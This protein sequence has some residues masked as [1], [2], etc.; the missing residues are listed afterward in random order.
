METITKEFQGEKLVVSN[1]D[2]LLVLSLDKVISGMINR[3]VSRSYLIEE[4]TKL[5]F[6]VSFNG[7]AANNVQI[8]QSSDNLTGERKDLVGN[9]SLNGEP[10]KSGRGRK[11]SEKGLKISEYI[12]HQR[13]VGWDDKKILDGII[14]SFNTSYQSAYQYLT[15]K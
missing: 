15:K 4:L 14:N 5:E 12:S 8:V 10:K 9:S 13:D 3:N 2:P 11:P 6:P 1:V 7:V